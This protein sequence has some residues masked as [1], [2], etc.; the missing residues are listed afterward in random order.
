MSAALRTLV[1]SSLAA[2]AACESAQPA[3]PWLLDVGGDT[4]ELAAWF[5][6]EQ[7]QPRAIFLFSPL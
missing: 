7:A 3:E 4:R 6:R 2:L 5:D 1:L